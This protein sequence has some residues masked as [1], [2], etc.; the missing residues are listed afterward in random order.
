LTRL[1]S[2]PP[3]VSPKLR[4]G[5]KVIAISRDGFDKVKTEGRE[6]SPFVLRYEDTSGRVHELKAKAIIDASGTWSQPNP[7]GANGLPAPSEQEA[8]DRIFYGIP[9]ILGGLRHRYAGRCRASSIRRMSRISYFGF[10][11]MQG[12]ADNDLSKISVN[13]K[14]GR[15]G[16]FRKEGLDR[17]LS[18]PHPLWS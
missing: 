18:K 12:C 15:S 14:G 2:N 11:P 10:A 4:L 6:R 9:D 1:A 16:L 5:S 7:L 3:E 13:L 17:R 8:R